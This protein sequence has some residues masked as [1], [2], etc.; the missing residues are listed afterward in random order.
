MPT[1][2]NFIIK[3]HSNIFIVDDNKIFA[4]ALKAYIENAFENSLITIYLFETGEKCL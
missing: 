1:T 4:L 2:T 3:K